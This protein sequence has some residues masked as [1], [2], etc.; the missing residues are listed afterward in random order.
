MKYRYLRIGWGVGEFMFLLGSL[1]GPDGV[2]FSRIRFALC[3]ESLGGAEKDS[4]RKIIGH[5]RKR[6]ARAYHLNKE[7]S[8]CRSLWDRRTWV[9]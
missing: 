7:I 9:G 3:C 6:E 8:K 1:L 4:G 5:K 2:D